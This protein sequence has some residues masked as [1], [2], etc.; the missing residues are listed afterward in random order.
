M[1]QERLNKSEDEHES[2][3]RYGSRTNNKSECVREKDREKWQ[4]KER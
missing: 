3:R 4:R 1:V 2:E